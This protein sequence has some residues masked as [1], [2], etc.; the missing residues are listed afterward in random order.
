MRGPEDSGVNVF[1]EGR[2]KISNLDASRRVAEMTPVWGRGDS[3]VNVFPEGRAKLRRLRAPPVCTPRM[4]TTLTPAIDHWPPWLSGQGVGLLIRRLRV[5][6]PQ[7]GDSFDRTRCLGCT[8][9]GSM[10][11]CHN[12][13]SHAAQWQMTLAG[14]EP[15]IFGSEDQRLIH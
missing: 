1:P 15:A 3:G 8:C 5:R 6:V 9:H 4:R 2:A 12:S 14:L 11:P 13:R 10:L 7:G